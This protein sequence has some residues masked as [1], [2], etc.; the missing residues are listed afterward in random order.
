MHWSN[1]KKGLFSTEGKTIQKKLR[2]SILMD[3]CINFESASRTLSIAMLSFPR[4]L[5][6]CAKASHVS[7]P[8]FPSVF[9]F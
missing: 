6:C 2:V 4:L 9:Y 5:K 1:E 7:I 3:L 8:D